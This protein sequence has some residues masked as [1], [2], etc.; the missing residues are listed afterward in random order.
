MCG[1]TRQATGDGELADGGAADADADAAADS[2]AAAPVAARPPLCDCT[3]AEL[4]A[5]FVR[6]WAAGALSQR[7]RHAT[8]SHKPSLAHLLV[9]SPAL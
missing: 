1:A 5:D 4:T 8:R 6:F 3:D 2:G 9:P 7:H